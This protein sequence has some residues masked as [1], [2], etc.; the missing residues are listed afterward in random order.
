MK[1]RTHDVGEG[2]SCDLCGGSGV[3]FAAEGA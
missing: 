2:E 1:K 3:D